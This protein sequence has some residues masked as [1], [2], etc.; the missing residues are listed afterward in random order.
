MHWWAWIVIGAILLGAELAFVE[1][2]FYLVFLGAAALVVGM[3][4]LGGVPLPAWGQWLTFA[5]LSVV[6]MVLFRGKVYQLLRKEVPTMKSGPVGDSVVTPIDL[7]PGDICRL[8]YRG[9]TWEARND[10]EQTIVAGS[11]ARI[12]R[13]DGLTLKISH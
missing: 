1:A 13:V 3:L 2:Q 10:G 9:T 5:L 4:D 8:E 6:S 12:L 7:E 11:E